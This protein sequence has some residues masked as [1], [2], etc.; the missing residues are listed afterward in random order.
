MDGFTLLELLVAITILAVVA[1][2]SWQGISSL[3]ATR[4]RLEPQDEEIRAAL[5]GFGQ[6]EIDLARAPINASLYALPVQAVR[7]FVID[8]QPSLQILRLAPSADGSRAAAVQSVVYQVRNGALQRASGPAQ[9]FYAHDSAMSPAAVVLVPGVAQIQLRVWRANV[10][11]ITP[12]S[13]ADSANTPGVE[14]RLQRADGSIL[15]RVFTVG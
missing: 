14:V 15:R 4:E 1:V 8:G 3:T 7:V 11:W 2:M 6:I 5:A 12:A 9:R 10:G 13:D